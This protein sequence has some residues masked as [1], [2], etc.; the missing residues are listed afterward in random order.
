MQ[1]ILERK[2]TRAPT[3]KHE[4]ENW[5]TVHQFGCVGAAEAYNMEG[6]QQLVYPRA[7]GAY[8]AA[9]MQQWEVRTGVS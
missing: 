9:A 2:A 5:E 4:T 7:P 3:R 1:I 8:P 6:A